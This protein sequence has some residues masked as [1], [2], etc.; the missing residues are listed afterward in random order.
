MK[1]KMTERVLTFRQ[2][3]EAKPDIADGYQLGL[4][5]LGA[6]SNKIVAANTRK[7]DG[8]VDID[9]C[10]KEKYPEEN[11]W[12]YAIG[13]DGNVYFV[14]VHPASAAE[15][16][17]VLQKLQWLKAWLQKEAP[18]INKKKANFPY[19]WVQTG[20]FQIPKNSRQ[21]FAA[22]AAHIRPVRSVPLP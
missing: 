2:A 11:R 15:V 21:N 14:E 10:T 18:E 4:Q 19:Y 9:T 17:V 12:D 22:A 13:Y 7:L 16:R 1:S 5:A 6:N 8:S 20:S 3:V